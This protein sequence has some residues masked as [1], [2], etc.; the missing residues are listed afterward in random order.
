MRLSIYH[1]STINLT[2]SC[3]SSLNSFK[4]SNDITSPKSKF[5]GSLFLTLQKQYIFFRQSLHISFLPI[6]Y[7][8]T[9]Y[10]PIMLCY[11]HHF[12]P[13]FQMLSSLIQCY[14]LALNPHHAIFYIAFC[15]EIHASVPHDFLIDDCKMLTC[16]FYCF[17]IKTCL[18]HFFM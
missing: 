10:L 4:S 1:F 2:A 17:Y 16:L 12:L 15:H 5:T 14:F 11:L 9:K 7:L 6:W 8:L 3:K 18:T 13:S